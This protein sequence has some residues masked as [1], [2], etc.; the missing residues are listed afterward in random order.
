M[1]I[2]ELLRAIASQVISRTLAVSTAW[3]QHNNPS[4]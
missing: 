2:E 3:E 4:N 1:D